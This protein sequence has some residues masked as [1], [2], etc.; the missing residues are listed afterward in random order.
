MKFLKLIVLVVIATSTT[1]LCAQ[2]EK[3]KKEDMVYRVV[4]QM[5]EYPGGKK[6][7]RQFLADNI[8]YP[9]QAKKD[10]ITGKVFVSFVI[11]KKGAVTQAKI[12]EGVDKSLDKEALRVVKAMPKWTPG[13][14]QGTPLKVQFTAP[15]M[16]AL[17]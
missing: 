6:A 12:E 13:K 3:V 1:T 10:E 15:I 16:F 4:D 2:N 5:P 14:H 8:K 11:D 17:K 7:M 9:A